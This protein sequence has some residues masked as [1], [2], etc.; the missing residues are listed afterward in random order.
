[1]HPLPHLSLSL[2]NLGGQSD[3]CVSLPDRSPQLWINPPEAFQQAAWSLCFVLVCQYTW[4][5]EY[6]MI[7]RDTNTERSV[8][9]PRLSTSPCHPYPC[10]SHFICSQ[11]TS[12]FSP[13]TTIRFILLR[14]VSVSRVGNGEPAIDI[15]CS[16]V[17]NSTFIPNKVMGLL[18]SGCGRVPQYRMYASKVGNLPKQLTSKTSLYLSSPVCWT[19]SLSDK[20]LYTA[21]KLFHCHCHPPVPF[22]FKGN[23]NYCRV[24]YKIHTLP[25]QTHFINHQTVWGPFYYYYLK[26][27]LP[28]T[29]CSDYLRLPQ[30]FWKAIS[31]SSLYIFTEMTWS[32][33]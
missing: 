24:S 6:K 5:P 33:M 14:E 13:K 12:S 1:M 2:P 19:Y 11:R 9:R 17:L 30:W 26:V 16:N 32:V 25:W 4:L 22:M 28:A 27:Q 3:T 23:E 7:H 15:C 20:I 18:K 29:W 31:Y 8:Y 10:L 21:E